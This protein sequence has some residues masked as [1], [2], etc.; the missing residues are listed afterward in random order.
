MYKLDLPP[1]SL[2]LKRNREVLVDYLKQAKAHADTLCAIF[3]QAKDLKPLDNALDYACKFTTRIQELLV[4]VNATCPSSR[5]ESAKLVTITPINKRVKSF[6]RASRSHPSG[7]TKKNKISPT[8]SNNQ[9]NKVEDHLRSVKSS[10]NKKNPVS[11]CNESTKQNVLKAN[12]KSVCKTCNECLFNACHDLCV[13]DYLNNVNVRAKSRSSTSNKK[14][15]WKPTSKVF[16]NVGHRW[17]PTGWTFTIDGNKCP[18]TRITSTTI[19]PP[20]QPILVKVVK[21]TI[22]SSNNLGKPKE[23]THVIQI[24]LCK[25][26]DTVRFGNDNVAAI[27]G[28]GDYQIGNVMI[29]QVYYVEGLGHSLFSVGQFCDFDLE[30]A[31]RKHTYF[32]RDLEGV[33]LLSRDQ[34]A[35][36]YT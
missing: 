28:Y 10:L 24:V 34:G 14:K 4:Y 8:T 20:K 7:N 9:N 16:T 29:S 36:I 18:L 35:Q 1:L 21:K 6:T 32:V 19:V 5:H 15:V 3:E 31:F 26:M 30:V 12:S 22:P 27:M 23:K 2:K 13:V 25:F 33:D 17:I 11:E